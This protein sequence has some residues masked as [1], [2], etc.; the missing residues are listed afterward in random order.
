MTSADPAGTHVQD[1]GDFLELPA[2]DG[3]DETRVDLSFEDDEI[4]DDGEESV[5]LDTST[6]MDEPDDVFD[7]EGEDEGE[8]AS[9][10]ASE[11]PV[12]ADP[13]LGDEDEEGWVAGSEAEDADF[14]DPFDDSDEEAG[15]TR[16][17][18]EEGVEERFDGEVLDDAP[19]RANE[20]TDGDEMAE[21]LDLQGEAEI[22]VLPENEHPALR[23]P[24]ELIE[25]QHLGA[26]D[27]EGVIRAAR[28]KEIEEASGPFSWILGGDVIRAWGP[29]EGPFQFHRARIEE[30]L[31]T[32]RVP[33]IGD[34]ETVFIVGAG[35]HVVVSVDGPGRVPLISSDDGRTWRELDVLHDAGAIAIAGGEGDAVLFAAIFVEEL[36]RAIVIRMPL[37]ERDAPTVV[38]D[39]GKLPFRGDQRIRRLK[40]ERQGEEMVL[41]VVSGI[42]VLRARI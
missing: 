14:D 38:I 7:D 21:D 40:L 1:D 16:D 4:E 19:V 11:E 30:V 29:P 22:D 15:L 33:R 24:R 35:K 5:G 41:F 18:G 10:E 25:V 6:G 34:Q 13:S 36:E 12:D 23:F 31:N 20:I 39:L 2:I 37:D 8:L 42:G 26:L 27:A 17:A 32:P 3:D 28:E 9:W